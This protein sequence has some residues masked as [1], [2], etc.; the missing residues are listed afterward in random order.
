MSTIRRARK[1]LSQVNPNLL[2]GGAIVG[3]VVIGGVLIWRA[4]DPAQ[5]PD[6]LKGK[7]DDKL[8]EI[9]DNAPGPAAALYT[10]TNPNTGETSTDNKSFLLTLFSPP[11]GLTVAA[12]RKV[13]NV[14]ETKD[15]P[16]AG[17]TNYTPPAGY[18]TETTAYDPYT[19]AAGYG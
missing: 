4:L 9:L 14:R 16:P 2:I 11:I 13:Q 8:S 19:A 17:Y 3:V 6:K 18:T 15:T 12:L 5:I 7:V 10:R 1:G